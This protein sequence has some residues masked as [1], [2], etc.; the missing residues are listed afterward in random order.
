MNFQNRDSRTTAIKTKIFNHDEHSDSIRGGII[1]NQTITN[2]AKAF[3]GESQARNRYT[4]YASV[5]KK[6]GYEQIAAIFLETAEQ[7]REHASILYKL[8]IELN[9]GK[10]PA[11]HI[12]TEVPLV[13]GTTLENLKAAMAGEQYEWGTMY[14]EFAETALKEGLKDVAAK[15]KGLIVAET[16]HEERYAKL[17]QLVELGFFK[18]EEEIEWTCQQCGHVHKGKQPPLQCPLCGHEKSFFQKKLEEY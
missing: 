13:R 17:V 12:E 1:M 10:E 16:H 9:G 7:E 14:P 15:F 6:E 8:L 11:L 4:M 3:V 18:R 2:L 5:A